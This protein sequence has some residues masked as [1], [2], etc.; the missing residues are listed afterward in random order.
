MFRVHLRY[1]LLVLFEGY[2]LVLMD[3]E[4]KPLVA[5][6]TFVADAAAVVLVVGVVA[7][8]VAVAV[9]KNKIKILFTE[10]LKY[11]KKFIQFILPVLIVRRH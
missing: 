9:A 1:P 7:L 8:A 6:A 5:A 3:F 11:A 4:L 10:I 2:S